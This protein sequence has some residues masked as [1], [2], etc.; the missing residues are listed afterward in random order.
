[1]VEV[2]LVA[3][4]PKNAPLTTLSANDLRLFDNGKPQIITTFARLSGNGAGAARAG[5]SPL[6]PRTQPSAQRL[7]II[8]LDALNTAFSDQIYARRAAAGMLDQLP[9]GDR[10]AIFVLGER[11]RLLH[12]FSSDPQGLKTLVQTFSGEHSPN[13][14]EAELAA[15]GPLAAEFSY[16][17]LVSQQQPVIGPDAAYYQ[18]MRIET[19][20]EA[21]ATIARLVKSTPGR[22]N[23]L[24]VSAAF[25]LTLPITDGAVMR[26]PGAYLKPGGNGPAPGV[27]VLAAP[28]PAS[29]ASAAVDSFH[30]PAE[31]MARELSAANLSLY[32]I[33]ARGLAVSSAA[34]INI[35]TMQ[36]LAERTGGKAFYNSNDL[37]GEVRAALDDSRESYVMTYAPRGLRDDG[38]FHSIR[39]RTSLH[40]VQLRYRPGYYADSPRSASHSAAG[41]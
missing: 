35:Q 7:S 25:P 12:E 13:S 3:T 31:R 23:L 40:G 38:S 10:I 5:G 6:D 21:L 24:W 16:E 1:V 11:L 22:K 20:L 41:R 26:D 8:L 9:P 14:D 4:G 19:T 36:E 15:S 2:T 34:F 27:P 28:A 29:G 37:T 39:L 17:D 32:P 30:Q 33:D 18:R